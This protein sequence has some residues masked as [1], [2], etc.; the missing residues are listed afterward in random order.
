LLRSEKAHF[1]IQRERAETALVRLNK[2]PLLSTDSLTVYGNDNLKT[3][4]NDRY[5][6]LLAGEIFFPCTGLVTA[7]ILLA[8]LGEDGQINPGLLNGSFALAVIGLADESIKVYTDP[9][10]S[11]KVFCE[12]DDV[13]SLLYTTSLHLRPRP[14]KKLDAAAIG[15]YLGNGVIYENRTAFASVSVIPAATR[16]EDRNGDVQQ[17]RYWQYK[18]TSVNA[19]VP[20]KE[21]L[22]QYKVLLVRSIEVRSGYQDHHFISISGGYDSAG[23]AGIMQLLG[24]T[25]PVFLIYTAK[26]NLAPMRS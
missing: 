3:A 12:A 23:I 5:L 26:L 22:E 20:E 19:D 13:G 15:S 24:R 11:R 25:Y 1:L 7:S 6:L 18:I 17:H 9:F 2:T 21:L 16:Q 4:G 8:Q 14:G 10:N